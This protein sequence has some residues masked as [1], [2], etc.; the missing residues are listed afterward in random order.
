VTHYGVDLSSFQGELTPAHIAALK[1]DQ[2]SF[3][4]VKATEGGQQNG[5]QNPDAA[6]QVNALR[7]AGIHVGLYHFFTPT[8]T[9]TSQVQLFLVTAAALGGSD[10][11]LVLDSETAAPWPTLASDMVNFAMQIEHEP[12]VVRCPLA[13]FYV[14]VNFYDNLEGFPW[15][16]LVWL[17]NPGVASPQ[18]PCLVWQTGEAGVAGTQFDTDVFMGDDTQWIS[19]ISSGQA[20]SPAPAAPSAPPSIAWQQYWKQNNPS[21]TPASPPPVPAPTPTPEFDVSTLPNLAAYSTGNLVKTVQAVLRDKFGQGTVVV[22][23]SFDGATVNAVENVQRFFKMPVTGKVGQAEW[24][25]LL[26]L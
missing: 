24:S 12:S 14:N 11:P 8:D 3:A 6:Q 20:P 10:L 17:A 23:G 19:F 5:Y 9:V 7:A 2:V 1:A 25:V 13:M 22:S 16:R 21:T 15:G 4:Y 18:K 26:E